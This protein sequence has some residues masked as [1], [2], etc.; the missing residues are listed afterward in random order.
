MPKNNKINIIIINSTIRVLQIQ[1]CKS[2][3]LEPWS[4]TWRNNE[5]IIITEII[6]LNAIEKNWPKV[7]DYFLKREIISA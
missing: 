4:I 5:V 2:R 7:C 1:I 3:R 6:Y